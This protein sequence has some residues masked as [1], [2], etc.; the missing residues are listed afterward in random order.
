MMNFQKT[1]LEKLGL[2]FI[3]SFNVELYKEPIGKLYNISFGHKI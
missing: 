3:S 2:L 1:I